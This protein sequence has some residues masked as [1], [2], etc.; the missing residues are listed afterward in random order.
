[1]PTNISTQAIVLRHANY[2]DSDRMLTLFSP[3][4][5]RID[6]LARGCR[7]GKGAL[8]G[9]TELFCLGE[10]QFYQRGDRYTLTG[11][12][13]Q[14][15]YYPLREDYDRLVHGVYLLGLCEATVQPGQEHT[16]LFAHLLE[17]LARLTYGG[18]EQ[19]TTALCTIFLLR[20][21]EEQGYRPQLE[22]CV[23]C[24][25]IPAPGSPLFFDPPG[26]GVRCA[27][28]SGGARRISREALDLLQGAQ[29]GEGAGNPPETV[30]QEALLNMRIYLE[31]RMEGR[32]KA[33]KLL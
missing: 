18:N 16:A 29:R 20:F 33:A 5:G 26:G 27:P 8:A 3:T 7:K 14:E 13:I 17:T 25:Q 30:A 32:I 23:R 2:R 31:G 6:A 24:G 15:S 28:C 12:S 21:A 11:C 22:R 1:M 9:A 10:Y 19:S 4:L